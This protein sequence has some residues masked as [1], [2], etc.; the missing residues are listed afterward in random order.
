MGVNC[1]HGG[2][3][4]ILKYKPTALDFDSASWALSYLPDLVF[5][6]ALLS[7]LTNLLALSGS[8]AVAVV[9]LDV[10]DVFYEGYSGCLDLK[11]L[12]N[13]RNYWL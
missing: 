6:V 4:C 8:V 12:K 1:L 7:N 10:F 11:K 9:D 3:L 5:N 2:Q 13:G